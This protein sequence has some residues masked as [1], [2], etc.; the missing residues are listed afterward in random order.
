VVKD[1]NELVIAMVGALGTDMETIQT[2]IEAALDEVGYEHHD[3]G[4]CQG[5]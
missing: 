5:I 2:Q 1:G 3:V 4:M